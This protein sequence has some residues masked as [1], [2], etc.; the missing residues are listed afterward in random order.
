[1]HAALGLP[2]RTGGIGHHA[3]IVRSRG[4]RAGL[5]VCRQDV[6]PQRQSRRLIVDARGGNELRHRQSGR[7]FEVIGIR[8]D[9]HMFELLAL[10]QRL[11]A[12]VQLL[13]HQQRVGAG[14]LGIAQDFL[15]EVHG[16]QRHHHGVRTQDAVVTNHELRA[17][18]HEQQHAIALAHA[19]TLL[20]VARDPFRLVV[21]FRETHLRVVVDQERLVGKAARRYFGVVEHIG[22]RR[23]QIMHRLTRP[24]FEMRVCHSLKPWAD[25]AT[26]PACRSAR[27]ALRPGRP[28]GAEFVPRPTAPPAESH[29]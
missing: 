17:I 22:G 10:E 19:A 4:Q 2:G 12:R 15:R 25:S 14:I 3:Q 13:R 16:V 9:D 6:F 27:G 20:Q 21:K 26:A 7:F 29:R 18:L 24:E 1:M 8:G 28:R 23:A 5:Q 11:D